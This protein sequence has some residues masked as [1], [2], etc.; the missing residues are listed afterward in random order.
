MRQECGACGG[1]TPVWSDVC[2]RCGL[3]LQSAKALRAAGVLYL[4]LGLFLSTV[5]AYVMLMLGGVVSPL[6]DTQSNFRFSGG[7]WGAVFVFGCISFVLLIGVTVTLMGAWQIR[8]GR[9]NPKLVRVAIVFYLI[10]VVGGTLLRIF[11]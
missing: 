9:R 8:Y 11:M 7:T 5:A 4:V 3:V 2:A 10:F 1:G 6:D